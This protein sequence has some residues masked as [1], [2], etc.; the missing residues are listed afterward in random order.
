[1]SATIQPGVLRLATSDLDARPLFWNEGA[2]RFGYEPE[3]AQAVADALNLRLEWVITDWAGRMTSV[4]SGESDGVWCGVS[5][6]DERKA[7]LDFTDPYAYFNEACVFRKGVHASSPEQ[8]KGLLIGAAAESTNLEMVRSWQGVNAVAFSDDTNDIFA[9]LIEATAAG[10]IDG[11]VDDEPAMVPLAERDSRLEFGFTVE[12]KRPWACGVRTGN[13]KLAA[14]L[15]EG[16]SLALASGE[17]ERIWDSHLPFL[18]FPL[19]S[20]RS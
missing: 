4:T 14:L 13:A 8:A 19:N 11:F 1:M 17:L 18:A 20:S 12:T 9:D 2:L 3:A 10:Q 6:T 7:I 15:N 16:L 5:L